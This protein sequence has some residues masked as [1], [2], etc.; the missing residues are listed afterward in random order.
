MV[1]DIELIRGKLAELETYVREL[2]TLRRIPRM[3]CG[4]TCLSSGRSSTASNYRFKSYWTW[5]TISCQTW[6]PRRETTPR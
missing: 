1:A 4:R 6:A 5:A 2:K 3:T